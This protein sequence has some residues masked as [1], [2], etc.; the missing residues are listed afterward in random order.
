VG[1]DR[2]ERRDYVIR[3]KNRPTAMLIWRSGLNRGNGDPP[4]ATKYVNCRQESK[5]KGTMDLFFKRKRFHEISTLFGR[6]HA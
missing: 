1:N 2:R 3:G 6:L 5:D 4:D